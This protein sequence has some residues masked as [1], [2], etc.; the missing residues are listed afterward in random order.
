VPFFTLPIDVR[1]NFLHR[2]LACVEFY[3]G[4]LTNLSET[5]LLKGS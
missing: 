3:C 4:I 2:P 5:T 1:S